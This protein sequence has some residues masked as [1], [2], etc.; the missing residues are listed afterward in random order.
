M[1]GSFA[2]PGDGFNVILRDALAVEVHLPEGGLR[3]CVALFRGFAVP[4]GSFGE[5]LRDAFAIVV[6]P[7]EDDLRLG[8]ALLGGRV[9]QLE[10]ELADFGGGA[11]VGFMILSILCVTQA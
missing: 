3:A 4:C 11:Q 6:H 10:P 8:V 5:I 9:V 2:M 1:L 7:P